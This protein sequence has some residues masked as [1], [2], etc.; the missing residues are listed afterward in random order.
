LNLVSKIDLNYWGHFFNFKGS[1]DR[2]SYDRYYA[3]LLWP[4]LGKVGNFNVS[5]YTDYFKFTPYEL[6][7]ANFLYYSYF[8]PMALRLL[9]EKINFIDK[10]INQIL[11]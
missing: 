7:R 6:L 8:S 2:L 4:S 11:K 5:L 1:S 10:L 3:F 9:F